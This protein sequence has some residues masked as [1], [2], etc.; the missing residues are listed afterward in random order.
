MARARLQQNAAQEGVHQDLVAVEKI[1]TS[2]E[3][4][5]IAR[6]CSQQKAAQEVVYQDLVAME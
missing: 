6:A 4:C 2:S 1:A 3:L 5:G